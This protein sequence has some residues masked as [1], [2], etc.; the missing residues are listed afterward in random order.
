MIDIEQ[1]SAKVMENES[2]YCSSSFQMPVNNQC[3]IDD[4]CLQDSTGNLQTI[5]AL[6]KELDLFR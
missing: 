4:K 1:E 5:H 3:S 6:K 2:D